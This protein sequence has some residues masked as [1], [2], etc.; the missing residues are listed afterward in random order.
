MSENIKISKK[1]L[2][3]QKELKTIKPNADNPFFKSKYADH[4]AINHVLMPLVIGAKCVVTHHTTTHDGNY[5]LHTH[6]TD[7]E[8]GEHVATFMPLILGKDT[9]QSLLAAITYAKRGNLTTLFNVD[10]SGEDDDGNT[11]AKGDNQR[12]PKKDAK[13]SASSDA[14]L[15]LQTAMKEL[16]KARKIAKGKQKKE[17]E[18]MIAQM[19]PGKA[20]IAEMTEDEISAGLELVNGAMLAVQAYIDKDVTE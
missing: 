5:F 11:A 19:A 18:K 14:G 1:V 17:A 13:P 2:Q 20:S 7:T 15:A 10:I 4:S 12:K 8:S 3:I 16:F 9:M 6:C